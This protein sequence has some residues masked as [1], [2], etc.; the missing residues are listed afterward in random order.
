MLSRSSANRSQIQSAGVSW[1]GS[2]IL[3]VQN[4]L[5]EREN[6]VYVLNTS[7]FYP[8]EFNPSRFLGS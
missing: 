5:I 2:D 7:V 4:D 1:S 8:V 6:C 3:D